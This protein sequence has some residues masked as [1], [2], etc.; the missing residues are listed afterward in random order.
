MAAVVTTRLP[1]EARFSVAVTRGSRQPVPEHVDEPAGSWVTS[2]LQPAG[3]WDALQPLLAGAGRSAV[4]RAVALGANGRIESEQEALEL[5]AID[6]EVLKRVHA[7][8]AAHF[9]IATTPELDVDFAASL[10]H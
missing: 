3:F 5:G 2:S 4:T 6:S 8:L 9:G 10:P 7:A 1:N